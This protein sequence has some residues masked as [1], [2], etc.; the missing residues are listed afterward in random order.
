MHPLCL[1]INTHEVPFYLNT[2]KYTVQ[3]LAQTAIKACFDL[4]RQRESVTRI[5][6]LNFPWVNYRPNSTLI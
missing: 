2:K 4:L 5:T 6:D 1:A 3:K